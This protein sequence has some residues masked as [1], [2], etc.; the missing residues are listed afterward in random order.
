M[1]FLFFPGLCSGMDFFY[2]DA[3]FVPDGDTIIL[4]DK[5]VVRYIGIDAP[6]V[7]HDKS[8]PQPFSET[9]RAFNKKTVWGKK[10]KIVI[11]KTRSDSYKRILAY[12]YL[13]DGRMVNELILEKGLAW[14]YYH[15]DN[16]EY[17]ERFL[18]VQQKAMKSGAGLWSDIYKIW[19]PVRINP[20]SMRFHSLTCKKS[21]NKSSI[22]KNPFNAFYKGYSPSRKCIKNIFEY[23]N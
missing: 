14:V 11:G 1:F 3:G 23:K 20:G 2:S 5:R 13:P 4:K 17:F 21:G 18:E 10:L 22:E 19:L 8:I 16:N 12:V 6:E 7:N 9:A 15:K